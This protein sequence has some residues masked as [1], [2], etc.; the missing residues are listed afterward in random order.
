M[1]SSK[2]CPRCQH[3]KPIGEFGI[4]RA[5]KDSLASYCRACCRAKSRDYHCLHSKEDNIRR[6]RYRDTARG[7]YFSLQTQAQKRGVKVDFLVEGFVDWFGRQDLHC[8]YCGRELEIHQR[9]LGA[10]TIDCTDN[11]TPYNLDNIALSCKRCNWAKGSWFTEKQMIAI[12]GRY[13]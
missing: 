8:H 5:K 4:N 12:A 11:A 6:A 2:F 3:E 9:G 7:R 13:F 10:L 1:G